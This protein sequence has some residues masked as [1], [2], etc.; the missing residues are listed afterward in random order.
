MV[1]GGSVLQAGHVRRLD[2]RELLGAA[3][4][5]LVAG[6]ALGRLT[7][8]PFAPG[9]DPRVAELDRLVSGP[10]IAPGS[11]A[12][13]TARLVYN[14]RFDGVRPLAIVRVNDVKDV[15]TVIGWAQRHGI[16]IVPRAGG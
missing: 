7:D 2:R 1:S 16:P 4:G 13:G 6:S 11:G 15:Q 3:A 10:V 8:E 9:L 14:E 12:Y 5:A